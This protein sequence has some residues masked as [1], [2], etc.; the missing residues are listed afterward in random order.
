[1]VS[2]GLFKENC[3]SCSSF[4]GQLWWW[5]FTQGSIPIE[6][7]TCDWCCQE[8]LQCSSNVSARLDLDA[9]IYFYGCI[10][11]VNIE[12]FNFLSDIKVTVPYIGCYRPTQRQWCIYSDKLLHRVHCLSLACITGMYERFFTKFS[13]GFVVLLAVD[14]AVL[15]LGCC[16]PTGLGILETWVSV[17]R[18]LETECWKSWS[19]GLKSWS[20]SWCLESQTWSWSVLRL[21]TVFVAVK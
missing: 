19:W 8:G 14:D 13:G 18:H 15:W 3:S 5:P 17:L 12:S 6:T 7:S 2:V 10:C 1:M 9:K 11:L 4:C 20:R 21:V 16:L